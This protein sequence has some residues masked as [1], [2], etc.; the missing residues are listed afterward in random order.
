MITY[1]K[2][3]FIVILTVFFAYGFVTSFKFTKASLTFFMV[4]K[5]DG[6]WFAL[7]YLAYAKDLWRDVHRGRTIYF[8]LT[9]FKLSEIL[10][11]Q[12]QIRHRLLSHIH[13]LHN[14]L[15]PISKLILIT[16]LLASLGSCALQLLYHFLQ[17]GFLNR[18][19]WLL[20]LNIDLFKPLQVM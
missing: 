3:V 15:I 1:K 9:T 10:L 16:R 19:L 2:F 7:I 8:D 17:M 11:G 14:W 4:T 5:Y 18:Y 13:H 6:I 12:I 20:L